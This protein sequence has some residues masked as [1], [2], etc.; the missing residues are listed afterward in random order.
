MQPTTSLRLFLC[1][2]AFSLLGVFQPQTTDAIEI[3]VDYRYDDNGFFDEPNRREAMQAVADRFSRVITSELLPVEPVIDVGFSTT[4]RIG[5][6][7]PST[8]QSYQ[9]STAADR[10]DDPLYSPGADNA[11]D[12]YGFPGLEA[13]KWLLFAGAQ[14]IGT[15]GRGG[16][17]TGLNYTNVFDD[18]D[19]PMHRGLISN[20]PGQ[21]TSD[22][23][24]WG[25]AITF[26]SEHDWDFSINSAN[27]R[28]SETDFYSI[29]MH[30]VG[31]ALGL[32][33]GWNQSE[34]HIE[35]SEYT[36][37]NALR[38]YNADNGTNR[39]SLDIQSANNSH[40]LDGAYQSKIFPLGE[41]NEYGT[42]GDGLQDLLL[43]PIA[44]FNSNVQRFELTNVD[45][46]ALVDL[47]WSILEAPDNPLDLDGNDELNGADVDL[48]CAAGNELQPYF[49]A[50]NSL[51]A[52]LDFDG[53]VGFS[54][55]LTLSANF[56]NLDA[57][58]SQGD[59][60]CDSMVGFEDFLSLSGA[61]G[62]SVDGAVHSVPEPNFT[63]LFCISLV[64]AALR[65]RS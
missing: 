51:S 42:V 45:A 11:A 31:H 24:V 23:P 53:E 12:E 47:G 59:V 17:G 62:S 48:A 54:D 52:D 57:T 29:A 61:F 3:V 32:S 55:F 49:D 64:I 30:E 18:L 10:N 2:L 8:G 35:G 25:G 34:Q 65:R 43:E 38:A 22:L 60:S 27:A 20:T 15:A 33:S 50:L 44:N 19:G 5:F 14:S 16:T 41:P 56:G 28:G 13:N 63:P 21:S 7:H 6:R 58:Y 26:D 40:W 36:G 1:C 37:E 46:A 4:W 9:I 39:T